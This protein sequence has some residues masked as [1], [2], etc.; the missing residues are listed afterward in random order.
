MPAQPQQFPDQKSQ[1]AKRPDLHTQNNLYQQRVQQ[2][3]PSVSSPY[4]FSTPS[5]PV[6][7]TS[8][9]SSSLSTQPTSSEAV[10]R[11]PPVKE[12]AHTLLLQIKQSVE[13]QAEASDDP[14]IFLMPLVASFHGHV[15][16][17]VFG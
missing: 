13:K 15:P 12:E 5:T 7:H 16:K 14:L 8:P 2:T 10:L 9:A 4:P 3:S 17:T 6:Y 11:P 1:E